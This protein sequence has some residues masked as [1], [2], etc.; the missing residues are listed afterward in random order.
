MVILV[1]WLKHS[2]VLIDRN[3]KFTQE[4]PKDENMASHVVLPEGFFQIGS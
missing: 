3:Y 1:A 4:V 2:L